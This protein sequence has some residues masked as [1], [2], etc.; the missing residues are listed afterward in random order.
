MQMDVAIKNIIQ[1]DNHLKEQA[2][3]IQSVPRYWSTDISLY[4]GDNPR[5]EAI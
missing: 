1:A 4:F 3:M 5:D 2:K